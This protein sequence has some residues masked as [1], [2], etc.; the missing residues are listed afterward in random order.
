[1]LSGLSNGSYKTGGGFEKNIDENENR[2]K[3]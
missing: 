3:K 1:L 2:G